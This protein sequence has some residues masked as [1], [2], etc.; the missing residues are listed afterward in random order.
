[1]GNP[2]YNM[3][4]NARDRAQNYYFFRLV[5]RRRPGSPTIYVFFLFIFDEANEDTCKTCF[6]EYHRIQD[7]TL[8]VSDQ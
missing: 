1:M 8:L 4:E 7:K 3:K 5:R 2:V 6:I